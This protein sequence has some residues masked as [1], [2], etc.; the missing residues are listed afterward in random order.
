VHDF[1]TVGAAAPLQE[2]AIAGLELPD[3]YYHGLRDLYTAKRDVFLNHLRATGLPFTE[4]HGAYYVLMDISSLGFTTDTEAAEWFVREIGVAGVPGSSFFREPEHRFIRF[5][6]AKQVET[7]N[8]AGEKLARLK[9][10]R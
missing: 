2:A 3:S 1:L 8:A 7:L 9:R 10:G 6:F 4:P 5:H